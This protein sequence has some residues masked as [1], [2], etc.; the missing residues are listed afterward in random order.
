M[1]PIDPM[2]IEAEME[3]ATA[4]RLIELIRAEADELADLLPK[5][6][7]VQWLP[8]RPTATE[9]GQPADPTG[10]TAT[11]PDRL[12]LRLQIIRSERLLRETA[13]ALRGVRLGL[14]TALDYEP[15]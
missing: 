10:E 4:E 1:R 11:D 3:T 8:V 7:S 15:L 12:A 2:T 6:T 9:P 13:I 5:A 14:A